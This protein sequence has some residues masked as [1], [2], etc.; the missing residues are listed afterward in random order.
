MTNGRVDLNCD[1]GESF[2]R[3]ELGD[4][5]QVMAHITSANIACGMHAG[6]PLVIDRSVALAARHKVAVGAHPGYPDLQGFG[7]RVIDLT[8][9]EAEA[10]TLYQV[11]AVA[12]FARAHNVDLVH[13]KPHGALYNQ[14]VRDTA[15][16][17]AVVRG[18]RRFSRG[19]IV[20][21][22]AGSVLLA[23]AQSAGLRAAS[24]GFPDRAYNPDGSLRSRRL[25]G[26]LLEALEEICDQA[27]RLTTQGIVI[28]GSKNLPVDTLCLHG[29]H[30]GA[31]KH[32][33]AVRQ[34]LEEKGIR[35]A[36]LE[37]A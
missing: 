11:S 34:A 1:L 4:D 9:E 7:R 24:E 20:V 30:P 5:E 6:D 28:D 13:V 35:V 2:G 23:E 8:P 25:P 10:F 36:P 15:L 29:D 18:V 32:A 26:A 17:A 37:R 16:A 21:G 31:A 3:Y 19:L 22:L 33:A 14:T 12:G 27:V